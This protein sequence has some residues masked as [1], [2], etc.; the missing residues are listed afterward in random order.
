MNIRFKMR[1]MFGIR[2]TLSALF[3]RTQ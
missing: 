2:K 3:N 1:S